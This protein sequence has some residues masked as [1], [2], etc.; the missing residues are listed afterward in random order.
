MQCRVDVWLVIFFAKELNENK[1]KRSTDVQVSNKSLLQ[2]NVV[3][4]ADA[5]ILDEQQ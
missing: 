5:D 2:R 3:V 4:C 1:L